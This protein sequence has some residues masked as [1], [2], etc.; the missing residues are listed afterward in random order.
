MVVESSGDSGGLLAAGFLLL[1]RACHHQLLEVEWP[2]TP[3]V[4]WLLV[5]NFHPLLVL[6]HPLFVGSN[7]VRLL[8]MMAV[9][10]EAVSQAEV[11]WVE[12]SRVEVRALPD[13]ALVG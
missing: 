4:L 11:S 13:T 5:P 12:G 6:L 3:V 7:G 1:D 2:L 9:K 10:L 8:V